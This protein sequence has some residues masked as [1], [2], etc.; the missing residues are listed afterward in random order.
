MLAEA[1]SLRAGGSLTIQRKPDNGGDKARA[2]THNTR[3]RAHTHS[4]GRVPLACLSPDKGACNMNARA[5]AA[6]SRRRRA[7]NGEGCA[8]SG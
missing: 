6:P 5:C 3:T 8:L 4:H 1:V 2:H 7:V